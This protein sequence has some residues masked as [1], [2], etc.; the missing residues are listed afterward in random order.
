MIRLLRFID[1]QGL[2]RLG[3]RLKNALIPT[4][5]KH[6]YIIPK[7]SPLSNLI[8]REA[9]QQTYHGSTQDTLSYIRQTYWILGG[10]TPIRSFILKCVKCMRYRRTHAQHIMGQLPA[11][12]VNPSR[13]F[14]HTG[15][16]Y[17]NPYVLKTWKAE[18]PAPTKH[19]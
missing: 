9:H 6:P 3:G 18:T 7:N 5:A 17:A 14:L 15:V 11:S 2:L 1:S 8:I 4:S 13:E 10:R 16:D 12:R 19:G